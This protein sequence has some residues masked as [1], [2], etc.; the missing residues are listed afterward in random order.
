MGA[1]VFGPDGDLSVSDALQRCGLRPG[2][3]E[4][5]SSAR[6]HEHP[7][8]VALRAELQRVLQEY[9]IAALVMPS[10]ERDSLGREALRGLDQIARANGLASARLDASFDEGVFA[11]VRQA[12][13]MSAALR[14]DDYCEVRSEQDSRLVKG[15]QLADLVAHTCATMLL[16]TLGLVKKQVK[17]GPNSGYDPDIELELGFELWAGLR[18]QFFHGGPVEGQEEVYQGALMRVG[19]HGL[20]IADTCSRELR[21]AA[22]NRFGECYLGCI[23]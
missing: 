16:E 2:I 21:D 9:R 22:D 8:Q 3:D 15:I 11:S 17:A 14:I 13:E 23:H 19:V 4:F 7:E 6:M 18:Y 12:L 5:K 10:T 1:Y 20:Y